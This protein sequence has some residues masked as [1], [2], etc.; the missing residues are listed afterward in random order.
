M[1]RSIRKLAQNGHRQ[2]IAYT[3][4]NRL[5]ETIVEDATWYGLSGSMSRLSD[6]EIASWTPSSLGV[7]TN[8][9]QKRLNVEIMYTM[10]ATPLETKGLNASTGAGKQRL[11]I[12]PVVWGKQLI[13]EVSL[14]SSGSL[15]VNRVIGVSLRNAV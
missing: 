6:F 11:A 2:L 13:G 7:G 9:Q 5:A 14:E 12:G 4:I 1:M 3:F 8:S 15:G 10:M